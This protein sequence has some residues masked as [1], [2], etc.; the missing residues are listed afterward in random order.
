MGAIFSSHLWA[1]AFTAFILSMFLLNCWT[2]EDLAQAQSWF[3][4]ISPLNFSWKLEYRC[5]TQNLCSESG[6]T[7]LTAGISPCREIHLQTIQRR[8]IQVANGLPS[9][10]Q[11]LWSKGMC[12]LSQVQISMSLGTTPKK[13]M[14]PPRQQ[15]LLLGKCNHLSL[16]PLLS[17][18]GLQTLSWYG[19]HQ[20]RWG[21][22]NQPK[23]PF[24]KHPKPWSK[25]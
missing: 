7:F 20:D 16:F 3:F 17:T 8:D 22:C 24:Y 9:V 11:S 15:P 6:N 25:Y 12:F 10:Y 23:T 14:T 19:I 21:V 5:L 4:R 18:V 2:E 13:Q 1:F